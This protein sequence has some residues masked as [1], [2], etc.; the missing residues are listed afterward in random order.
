MHA[1]CVWAFD[2]WADSSEA[3]SSA[4]GIV[5]AEIAA[6][7][8]EVCAV[9]TAAVAVAGFEAVA[10]AFAPARAR[11]PVFAASADVAVDMSAVVLP[12]AT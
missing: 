4:W 2:S 11:G 12:F 10:V 9:G 8:A 1:T 3:C 7:L 6:A 5:P